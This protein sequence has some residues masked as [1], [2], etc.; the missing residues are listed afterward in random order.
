M[1][2]SRRPANRPGEERQQVVEWLRE[3]LA[4]GPKLAVE[5]RQAAEAHGFSLGTLRRAFRAL[6]GEVVK[7]SGEAH[8]GW[9]WQL[10]SDGMQDDQKSDPVVL[11]AL[12]GQDA[13]LPGAGVVSALGALT[14]IA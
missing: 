1:N 11:S 3:Y 12:G 4:D 8:G 9:H 2:E 7:S 6:G 13:Q 5:V 14:P 10:P